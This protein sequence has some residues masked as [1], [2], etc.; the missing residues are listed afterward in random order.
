[1][2]QGPEAKVGDIIFG[3][4]P[5]YAGDNLYFGLFRKR[6]KETDQSSV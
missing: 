5:Q 1:M 3:A 2:V 6:L 4:E